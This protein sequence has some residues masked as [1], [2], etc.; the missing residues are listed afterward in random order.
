MG[1]GIGASGEGGL[2][3]LYGQQ[4]VYQTESL[5]DKLD[6]YIWAEQLSHR[7]DPYMAILH[8][9]MGCQMAYELFPTNGC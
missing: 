2:G 4:S 3:R 8:L 5:W 1:C 6:L 7:A 9:N